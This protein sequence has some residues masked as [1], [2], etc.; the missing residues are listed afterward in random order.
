[1]L[2]FIAV[3]LGILIGIFVPVEIST[4]YAPFVAIALLAGL[5]TIFGGWVA[6]INRKFNLKIFLTGFFGNS[7][8]AVGLLYIGRLLGIDLTI[9]AVVVFGT[10]L[11]NNFATLR[12]YW[13]EELGKYLKKQKK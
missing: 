7:L 12:R 3:I 4:N 11:F 5:D 2:F 13:L 8:L 6:H 1:M 10:R 9:A